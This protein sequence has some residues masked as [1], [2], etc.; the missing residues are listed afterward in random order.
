MMKNLFKSVI[1]FFLITLIILN[2]DLNAY[3]ETKNTTSEQ[4]ITYQLSLEEKNYFLNN[5]IDTKYLISMSNNE[6][7]S[8]DNN[9]WMLSFIY[10]GLGQMFMGQFGLGSLFAIIPIIIMGFAM[11]FLADFNR[12][13]Q[14]GGVSF[15]P[16]EIAIGLPA[17]LLLSIN[18]ISNL[19][20]AYSTSQKISANIKEKNY[21]EQELPYLWMS[22]I[23]VPGSG[24]VLSGEILKGLGFFIVE[25]L[26]LFSGFIVAS[27]SSSPVGIFA[28]TPFIMFHIWNVTDSYNEFKNGSNVI[29]NR[30]N[31]DPSLFV[32]N[33]SFNSD[34]KITSLDNKSFNVKV[35]VYNS[36]F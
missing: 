5:N 17:L 16:A 12:G 20:N 7:N 2:A 23:I 18:Y 28:Y 36:S 3:A 13:I 11:F 25:L 1:S 14:S 29:E 10:P 22:S 32:K 31:I 24:Q 21:L 30:D 19:I 8:K 15:I 26:V 9:L 6:S 4:V 35:L 33:N 27:I 34:Y